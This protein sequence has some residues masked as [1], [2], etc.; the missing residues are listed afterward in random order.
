MKSMHSASTD[1]DTRP[2]RTEVP[3]THRATAHEGKLTACHQPGPSLSAAPL[4]TV[5][6]V[7]FEHDM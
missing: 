7:H 2:L 5:I 3:L 1:Y 4:D 6:S